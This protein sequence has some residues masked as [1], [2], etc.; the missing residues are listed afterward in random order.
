MGHGAQPPGMD[1]GIVLV[2]AGEGWGKSAAALGYV[3]RAWARGWRVCV[4]QFV[5][6]AAWNVAERAL[7]AHLQV[8]WH[9]F[10]P[11]MVWDAGHARGPV[12]LGHRAW[13]VAAGRISSGSYHLVVL[14]ELG[15]AL[16]AGWLDLAQVLAGLR[17]RHEGT[18]VIIT[19]REVPDKVCELAD[20]VTRYER[21]KHHVQRG[22]LR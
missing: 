1:E 2:L 7:A 5:K 14:D 3:G 11:G 18:N 10:D 15:N 6:G 17:A 21:A 20:T 9:T 16:T 12:E 8:E 13:E 19:G 22:I 4:V